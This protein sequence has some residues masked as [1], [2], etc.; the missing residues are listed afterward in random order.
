M[1]GVLRLLRRPPRPCSIDKSSS[2]DM[3]WSKSRNCLFTNEVSGPR[4]E[5]SCCQRPAFLAVDRI[6]GYCGNVFVSSSMRCCVDINK[7]SL[8]HE[9]EL[10]DICCVG[11]ESLG[12][13][14][15]DGIVPGLWL[16]ES[17]LRAR[18]F[19]SLVGGDD[20]IVRNE[21]GRTWVSW[22]DVS[23]NACKCRRWESDASNV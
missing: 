21:A 2:S 17:S 10:C 15:S 18:A 14:D 13:G 6:A 11:F 16:R 4:S 7:S 22:M 9:M 1:P 19:P 3:P 20:C 8:F 5:R 23:R 12:G